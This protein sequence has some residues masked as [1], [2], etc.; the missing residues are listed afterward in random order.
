MIS[1]KNFFTLNF[2][3]FLQLPLPSAPAAFPLPKYKYLTEHDISIQ[4]NMILVIGFEIASLSVASDENT[5][6]CEVLII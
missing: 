3:L 5:L 6:Y 2:P 4:P 1:Y